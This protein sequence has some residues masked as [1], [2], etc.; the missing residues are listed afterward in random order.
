MTNSANVTVRSRLWN[1]TMLEVRRHVDRRLSWLNFRGLGLDRVCVCVYLCLCVQDYPGALRV[2]VR[3]EATLQLMTDHPHIKMDSQTSIVSDDDDDN[4]DII[5]IGWLFYFGAVCRR[6]GGVSVCIMWHWDM[7]PFISVFVTVHS[8]YWPCGGGD[9]TLRA[10]TVDHHL[11]SCG[12][13]FTAG[14]N[15]SYLVEGESATGSISDCVISP[16]QASRCLWERW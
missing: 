9:D 3:G 15:H 7:L 12:R 13:N 11:C 4:D 1:S 16:E 6:S 10:P 8:I 5:S 14:N 2:T